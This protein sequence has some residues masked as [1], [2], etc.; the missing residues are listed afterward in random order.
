[1][2]PGNHHWASIGNHL[3]SVSVYVCL[4]GKGGAHES[5]VRISDYCNHIEL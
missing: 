3:I 2:K 1:M 4:I 5:A